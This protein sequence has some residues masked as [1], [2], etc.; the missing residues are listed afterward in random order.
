LTEAEEMKC[1]ELLNTL[2]EEMRSTFSEYRI[3][4]D[5]FGPLQVVDYDGITGTDNVDD[6][7]FKIECKQKKS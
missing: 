3:P 7:E 2:N 1:K 5:F 4:K 6:A